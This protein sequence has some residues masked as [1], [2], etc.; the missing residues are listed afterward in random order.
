MNR[1]HQVLIVGGGWA[2]VSAA[3]AAKKAGAEVGICERTDML[4]G[5]GLVGGIMRNNGRL[6]ATGEAI[7]MG[8]GDLFELAESILAPQEHLVPGP[9]A[10]EPV[11]T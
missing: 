4:L 11:M 9:Q 2:G 7:A 3:I 1:H 10:R 5:A 8:F 6:V